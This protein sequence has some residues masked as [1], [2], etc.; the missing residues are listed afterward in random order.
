M[1]S[2]TFGIR[3]FVHLTLISQHCCHRRHVYPQL[4]S[5]RSSGPLIKRLTGPPQRLSCVW[6]QQQGASLEAGA[7]SSS[8]FRTLQSWR[9]HRQTSIQQPK[10][11]LHPLDPAGQAMVR[12]PLVQRP[13]LVQGPIVHLHP[14]SLCLGATMAL[15][16]CMLCT[17]TCTASMILGPVRQP[18]CC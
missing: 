6:H 5:A 2:F 10:A 17:M 18:A 7:G 14:Q 11:T 8:V 12:Q 15:H 9:G 13:L 3:P 1:P 4:G 16:Q